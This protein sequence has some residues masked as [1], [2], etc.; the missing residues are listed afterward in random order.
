MKLKPNCLEFYDIGELITFIERFHLNNCF[1]LANQLI[2]N[3]GT[4]MVKSHSLI[5]DAILKRLISIQED[6]EPTFKILIN[7]FIW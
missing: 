2:D 6:F 3:S 5:S 4:V 7:R 1:Q